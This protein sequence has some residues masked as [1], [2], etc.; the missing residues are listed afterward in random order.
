MPRGAWPLD[1]PSPGYSARGCRGVLSL[2]SP[3]CVRLQQDG[4]T[5]RLLHAAVNCKDQRKHANPH[6]AQQ[7]GGENEIGLCSVVRRGDWLQMQS[8]G[9]GDDEKIQS[10]LWHGREE[11]GKVSDR[12]HNTS[13]TSSRKTEG[14]RAVVAH[15]AAV[16][17]LHG[18]GSCVC[19]LGVCTARIGRSKEGLKGCERRRG[20]L[21]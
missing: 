21:Q 11:G 10:Q 14:K 16:D 18:A 2:S 1:M 5:S 13:R 12:G 7:D 15:A 6:N 19:E 4:R 20:D 17:G 8:Q 3:P 9:K